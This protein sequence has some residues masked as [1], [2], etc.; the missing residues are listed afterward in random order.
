MLDLGHFIQL[1]VCYIHVEPCKEVSRSFVPQ[2]SSFGLG[3]NASEKAGQLSY[4]REEEE[5]E[6]GYHLVAHGLPIYEDMTG[7]RATGMYEIAQ[8]AFSSAKL[9]KTCSINQHA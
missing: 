6:E 1:E 2:E 5:E 3:G 4:V 9:D 8:I 7:A